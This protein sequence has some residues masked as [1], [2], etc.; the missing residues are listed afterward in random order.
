M[1]LDL[2][3]KISHLLFPKAIVLLPDELKELICEKAT[4]FLIT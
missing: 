2:F 3:P 4:N 1:T